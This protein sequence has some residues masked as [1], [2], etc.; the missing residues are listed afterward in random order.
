MLPCK[1][2]TDLGNRPFHI[3]HWE[4]KYLNIK[5]TFNFMRRRL[6][7]YDVY[8]LGKTIKHVRPVVKIKDNISQVPVCFAKNMETSYFIVL[9]LMQFILSSLCMGFPQRHHTYFYLWIKHISLSQ[10]ANAWHLNV[11]LFVKTSRDYILKSQQRPSV[12]SPCPKSRLIPIA[13]P[14]CILRHID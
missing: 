9:M 1:D 12:S 5:E 10:Q 13:L 14:S 7:Y 2:G 6:R 3:P 4:I 8:H 11:R